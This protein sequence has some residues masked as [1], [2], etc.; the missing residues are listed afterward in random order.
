MLCK[1]FFGYSLGI[2]PYVAAKFCV[3]LLSQRNSLAVRDLGPSRS[4]RVFPRRKTFTEVFFKSFPV[5]PYFRFVKAKPFF[6]DYLMIDQ[7]IIFAMIQLFLP[8]HFRRPSAYTRALADTLKNT[9]YSN[10][11]RHFAATYLDK[12]L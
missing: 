3:V 6:T 2:K 12:N 1:I 11:S 8:R 9:S 7:D 10:L 4:Q 5:R